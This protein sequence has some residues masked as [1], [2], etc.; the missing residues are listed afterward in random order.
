MK[1]PLV[2]VAIPTYNRANFIGEAIKSVL[3]QTH[4]DFELLIVDNC[5]SDKTSEIVKSFNDERIKYH[6]NEQ[7]IGMLKNWNRCI[8]LAKGK[9]LLVLGDDDKLYPPFL[10]ESLLIYKKYPKL[11]FTFTHCNKVDEDGNFIMRWG[12]NFPPAGYI[13][14]RDYL[15]DTIKYGCNLTNSS[16]T[17]LRKK[18]FEK[19][20]KFQAEFATNT[21]DFNM[22]VR[23]A[24]KFDV[25]FID[26][27]LVDYRLH[28][29]Q[30]SEL[31][32]RRLEKP[33]GKIGSYLEVLKAISILMRSDY[34]KDRNH[35]QFLSKRLT[36]L[37]KQCK[38][39][40]IRIMPNL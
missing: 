1:K 25:Y 13:E 32:W 19:V 15:T 10:K 8:K 30:V 29:D 31:H 23:I 14:G 37:N 26:K 4:K 11:G 6:K 27:V 5:S 24:E 40:L 33:T 36:E 20:G 18:V 21:F 12:Y 7:N 17:L 34:S 35:R 22:W 28:S 38:E 9:Y 3:D 2:S 16:T 39:L